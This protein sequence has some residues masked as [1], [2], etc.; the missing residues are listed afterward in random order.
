MTLA[1]ARK[2]KKGAWIAADTLFTSNAS[3]IRSK[4]TGLKIFFLSPDILV[5]YSGDPHLAHETIRKAYTSLD[6]RTCALDFCRALEDNLDEAEIDFL[7]AC[8]GELSSL[9]HG[10]ITHN[11]PTWIGDQTGFDDFQRHLAKLKE[12]RSSSDAAA[13]WMINRAN[14]LI[15][16]R[17]SLQGSDEQLTEA[18][19]FHD[20]LQLVINDSN[21]WTVGGEAVLACSTDRGAGY[22]SFSRATSPKLEYSRNMGWNNIDFGT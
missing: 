16:N 4:D 5:S 18:L 1:I 2:L 20:A 15:V 3:N 10:K 14:L 6:G 7:V 17:D 22:V 8:G 9:K 11:E 19:E 13:P 21:H 12:Q